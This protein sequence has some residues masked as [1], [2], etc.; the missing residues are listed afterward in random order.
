MYI[1]A[2]FFGDDTFSHLIDTNKLNAA[3]KVEIETKILSQR[4][5]EFNGDNYFTDIQVGMVLPKSILPIII[6]A[7]IDVYL[8]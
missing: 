2:T 6:E 1:V 7:M 5:F 8:D 4:V 3:L